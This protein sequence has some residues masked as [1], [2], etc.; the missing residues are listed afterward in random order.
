MVKPSEKRDVKFNQ[1]VTVHRSRCEFIYE[2][3][4]ESSRLCVY[5]L[6][7]QPA[8]EQG[9]SYVWGLYSTESELLLATGAKPQQT[10]AACVSEG[11]KALAK[12]NKEQGSQTIMTG[13]AG[14]LHY[15]FADSVLDA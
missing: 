3:V 14:V 15:A 7:V 5:R 9:G 12:L 8:A 2:C 11:E 4:E 6:V 1:R 13:A 10:V